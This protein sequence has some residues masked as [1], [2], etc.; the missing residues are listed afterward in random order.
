MESRH[1][2]RGPGARQLLSSA[3]TGEPPPPTYGAR[4][5]APAPEGLA[6]QLDDRKSPQQASEHGPDL[7]VSEIRRPF[8]R[9]PEKI[10]G[11]LPLL[12]FLEFCH[13]FCELV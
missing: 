9:G 1:A 4:S 11:C 10:T 7:I 2:A 13:F 5:R 12:L 6:D 8:S 3:I